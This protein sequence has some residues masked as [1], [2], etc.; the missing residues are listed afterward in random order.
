MTD[1]ARQL[2]ALL[3]GGEA[4]ANPF[5]PQSRYHVVPTTTLIG[6]DGRTI[7][8]LRRRFIPPPESFAAVQEHTVVQGDR[9]DNIAARYLGDPELFWRLCDANVA[10]RPTELTETLGRRILITLP[11]GMR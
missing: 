2:Q 9:L 7:V 11:E 3:Q 5:P 6:P 1:P 10:M 4:A 8:Y